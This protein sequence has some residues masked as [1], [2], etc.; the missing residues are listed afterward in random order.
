MLRAPC[1]STFG[2]TSG[3]SSEIVA[4]ENEFATAATN[5]EVPGMGIRTMAND[6]Q[7]A[8]STTPTAPKY[9]PIY[10]TA[11]ETIYTSNQ[12]DIFPTPQPA[13]NQDQKIPPR[14]DSERQ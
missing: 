1:C 7:T 2:T 3:L 9:Q 6:M 10:P 14:W 4:T 13:Q 5:H 8:Q 11:P 12:A